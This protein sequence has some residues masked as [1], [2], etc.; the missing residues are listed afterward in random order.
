MSVVR[1]STAHTRGIRKTCRL[2]CRVSCS[3]SRIGAWRRRADLQALVERSRPICERAGLCRSKQDA[4][5]ISSAVLGD[6]F[7]R[8]IGCCHP[9]GKQA[10]ALLTVLLLVRRAAVEGKLSVP[11]TGFQPIKKPLPGTLIAR[12]ATPERALRLKQ[13]GQCIVAI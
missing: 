12:H 5:P 3:G 1:I 11:S 2:P 8:R 7:G 6:L 9:T 4:S 10:T 13:K